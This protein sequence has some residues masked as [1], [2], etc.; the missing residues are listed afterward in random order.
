MLHFRLKN[1]GLQ[2][3]FKLSELACLSSFKHQRPIKLV[4][5]L[6]IPVNMLWPVAEF[7]QV[8]AVEKSANSDDECNFADSSK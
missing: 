4:D 8:D 5:A 1:A 2:I 3:G 6:H 7:K